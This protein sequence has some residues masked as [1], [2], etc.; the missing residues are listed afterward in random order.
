MLRNKKQ[1]FW[2]T[3]D[4]REIP[5]SEMEDIHVL[6]SIRLL[7]HRQVQLGLTVP[8]GDA[9]SNFREWSIEESSAQLEM[10]EKEA[11]RRKLSDWSKF[12]IEFAKKALGD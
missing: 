6:R 9:A 7:K 2:R 10:L 11:N 5:V 4:G 12:G 1:D 3:K 8:E